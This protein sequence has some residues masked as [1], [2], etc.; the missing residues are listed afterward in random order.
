MK[1]LLAGILFAFFPWGQPQI[2]QCIPSPAPVVSS[3]SMLGTTSQGSTGTGR[4]GGGWLQGDYIVTTVSETVSSC[5]EY[6]TTT[7]AGTSV[8]CILIAGNGT[9]MTSN[10]PVCYSTYT[11]TGS[12]SGWVTWPLTTC[13]TVPA[14]DYWILSNTNDTTQQLGTW[15]CGSTCSGAAGSATYK[16]RFVG[17]AYGTY[18]GLYQGLTALSTA[19]Q[20]SIYLTVSP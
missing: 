12:E 15:T 14:G 7:T 6:L 4:S 17:V 13:G 11:E 18:T 8:D 2:L 20:I 19:I 3:G 5:S 16:G 1:M 10:T 9:G